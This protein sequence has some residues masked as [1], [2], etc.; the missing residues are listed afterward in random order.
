VGRRDRVSAGLEAVG[1]QEARKSFA[2]ERQQKRKKRIV[3]VVLCTN[4]IGKKPDRE[5]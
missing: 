1:R 3:Y 5:Q 2:Q 4:P